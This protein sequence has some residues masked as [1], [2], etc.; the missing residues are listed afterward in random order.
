[1]EAFADKDTLAIAADTAGAFTAFLLAEYGPEIF[2]QPIGQNEYR[3]E[4]LDSLGVSV[5]YAPKYDLTILDEAQI[6]SSEDYALIVTTQDR[7]FSFADNVAES[8]EPILETL[9]YYPTGME[10]VLS[11]VETNAPD[12]YAEIEPLLDE[13][14]YYYFDGDLIGVRLDTSKRSLY[15]AA[16]SITSLFLETFWYL[17]PEAK[18]ETQI[19]KSY[20]LGLYLLSVADVPISNYYDFFHVSSEQLT[21]DSAIYMSMVQEYYLE[22]AAYPEKLTDFDF[23]LLF[24][25]LA[26]GLLRNPDLDL[27][28][29]RMSVMTIAET[30]GQERNYLRYPGNDLTSPEAYLFTEYLVNTYGL[31]KMI[32]YC[33]T[34][35]TLAFENTF[36]LSYAE[37]FDDFRTEYDIS[38]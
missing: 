28:Y 1:M 12:N 19:W 2:L 26:M 29:P 6:T 20:G 11:Y 38:P 14:F 25:A 30:T 7:V 22:H 18:G 37:V 3:Q 13:P 34:Y 5:A 10:N 17:I 8:P 16:P 33:T 15:L 27:Y 35:S 24:E 23:G 36:G 21:G 4:F 31:E 9:A 32:A